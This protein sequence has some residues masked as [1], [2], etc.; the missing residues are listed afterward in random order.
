MLDMVGY[1]L[2]HHLGTVPGLLRGEA[3]PGMMLVPQKYK[4]MLPKLPDSFQ[5]VRSFYSG[6][7]TP[8]AGVLRGGAG[9]PQPEKIGQELSP[10]QK[11]R[12]RMKRYA[13]SALAGAA[14]YGAGRGLGYGMT[15]M[16]GSSHPQ[17]MNSKLMQ[18]VL[19]GG[20]VAAGILSAL[21]AQEHMQYTD[22]E[23]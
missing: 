16:L 12:N 7:K 5:E 6:G 10:K 1:G 11:H 4:Q 22:E 3:H 18:A 8:Y 21:A 20:P 15:R 14:G 2:S 9:L 17:A 19:H 13:L 23:D